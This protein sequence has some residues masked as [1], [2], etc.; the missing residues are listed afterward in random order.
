LILKFINQN[1]LD[2]VY[3]LTYEEYLRQGY[4][5]ENPNKSLSLYPH[6]DNILETTVIGCF[7]HNK[8]LGTISWTLDGPNKLHTDIDFPKETEKV[9]QEGRILAASWRIITDHNYR[10]KISVVSSLILATIEEMMIGNVQ[11]AL[12]TFNPKHERVYRRILN[13]KTLARHDGT[14]HGMDNAPAVLMRLDI[15][16]LHPKWIQNIIDKYN[17]FMIERGIQKHD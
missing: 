2:L 1:E 9:R 17:L 6:L 8:L 15:E 12:F 5:I 13:M 3:K 11:T 10:H 14:I 4:I 7:D 16:N